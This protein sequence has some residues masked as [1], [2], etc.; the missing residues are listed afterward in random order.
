[1]TRRPTF[2]AALGAFALLVA[3]CGSDDKPGSSAADA[4][5]AAA[6]PTT[7]ASAATSASET[8]VAGVPATQ[9]TAPPTTEPLAKLRI[10]HPETLAFAAPFTFIADEPALDGAVEQVTTDVWATPDVMRALV[11]G[12]DSD[13]TAVPS[14]VA[15][16]LFNRGVDIRLAAI[17]VWGLLWVIG[18]DG[19][20]ADWEQLRGKTVM[21]PYANDMP[22]LVFRRLAAANGLDPDTDMKIEYYAQPPEVVGR[23]VAG[24]GTY[25]VLPE[26]VATLALLTANDAGRN[27]GRMFDLQQ[28]WAKITGGSA[29][30]PQ[31]GVI[32]TAKLADER[33]DVV[34]ALL[35][36]LDASIDRVN[37]AVPAD[38][39]ALAVASGLPEPVVRQVVERLNLDMVPADEA[40]AELERFF[41][42]LAELSPEIIG[43]QSPG[44][45]LYLVDPR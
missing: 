32:V 43:G 20:P 11:V 1:M 39:A 7:A 44:E 40:R 8:T 30:I 33:P 18:P 45:D 15:A 28:E 2:I 3:A 22:D 42:E 21:V 31:A 23:L 26:H 12:G 5:T 37:A 10:Y 25:A 17:T 16:N 34:G 36:A 4:T 6:S 38:V 9:S 35:D 14:Y 19:M 41:S 27:L 13:V 29:R 24:Q